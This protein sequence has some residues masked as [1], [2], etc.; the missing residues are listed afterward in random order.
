MSGFDANAF[1]NNE[2]ELSDPR[3]VAAQPSAPQASIKFNANDFLGN[4]EGIGDTSNL[5]QRLADYEKSAP[6][7]TFGQQLGAIAEGAA[8]GL[9]GPVATGVE[10]GLSKYGFP[11]LTPENQET[12][13]KNFPLE[14]YGSEVA[15][16]GL[17]SLYGVGEAG[18]VAK[19]GHAAVEASDLA[20]GAKLTRAAVSGGSELAAIQA[21]NEVSSAI[22]QDP[23][24]TLG[25]AAIHMTL[26]GVL[27]AAGGAALGVPGKMWSSYTGQ[28]AKD[29]GVGTAA[30]SDGED[31][32]SQAIQKPAEKARF[33]DGL[34]KQK[35]NADEI[36]AAGDLI[37]VPV[38]SSQTS[39][40]DFVQSLDSALSQSPT[41]AGVVR[42]QEIDNGFE[43]IGNIV[44]G[45]MGP[46][47]ETSH[48][49]RGQVIKDQIQRKVDELYDPLRAG[50]ASRGETNKAI[51]IPDNARLKFYDK[52]TEISQ[53]TGEVDGPGEKV[54]SD[55]A[56][57]MLKQNT[58]A[59]LDDLISA[60]GNE[61][62]S[63][64]G[65]QQDHVAH[66]IGL[67]Q[68]EIKQF[69]VKQIALA[70]KNLEKLGVTGA[71]NIAS[72]AVEEFK[73]LSKKYADF[74]DTLTELATGSKLG[75]G[76]STYG[77]VEHVL[78]KIP[79]EKLVEK[80]FDPKNSS[81]L[82]TMKEKFPE[83]FESVIKGKRSDMVAAANGNN[84]SLLDSI[85]G[86]NKKGV[87][88]LS[89]EIRAMM[90]TPEEL[91]MMKAS[92]TWIE[93]L[94]KNVGPSGTPKGQA[95][96]SQLNR[97]VDH[98]LETVIGNSKDFAI[99][100]LLK[101]ATPQ[102]LEK[103]KALGEY[104]NSSISGEKTLDRA[105]KAFLKSGEIIPQHLMPNEKSR[106][107]LKKHLESMNEN[108]SSMINVGGNI[109]HY[110]PNHA[111]AAGTIAAVAQ[112]YFNS[113]KPTQLVRSP[114][115]EKPPVDKMAEYKYNRALDIAQQ[116]LMVLQHAKNGT[117]QA[118]DLQTVGALYPSLRGQIA[119]KL[120][121]E[122]I[123]HVNA[124]KPIPYIERQMLSMLIGSPL[125]STMTQA[126]AQSIMISN[127]PAQQ[128][129]AS[130]HGKPHKASGTTLTQ[131]NK[132]NSMLQTP[133]EQRQMNRKA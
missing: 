55:I 25:T 68:Q 45:I 80:M 133:L 124:K 82:E 35:P 4:E 41:I 61:Q 5:D 121:T 78:E 81:A 108:P 103:N 93:S 114:L 71:E 85:F 19:L 20:K 54:I 106:D 97:L 70:G 122:M 49:V 43:K 109:G 21:G 65:A 62:R 3:P 51:Q 18:L 50:Y 73:T 40:S 1:L 36:K 107:R 33:L 116:P 86:V 53:K 24:Q 11:G 44:D 117:L 125:D 74:K 132:V 46:V 128:Q 31:I 100:T 16:F 13:A 47:D 34:K 104:I 17:S 94:P 63:A 95:Y 91:Q 130:Q 2:P 111:A 15:S 105:A 8:Q 99:K 96:M 79:N 22:N 127:S 29:A 69:Q 10:A 37:G 39:A 23:N 14:R 57:R 30:V 92:R 98:P 87:P 6:D 27:G 28:A 126:A 84:K 102:E 118:Q 58:A 110:L 38:S 64:Y 88:N 59:N 72:Q 56:E 76:F 7:R 66:A 9:L 67:A 83:V 119:S 120:S 89:P 129:A 112:N 32:L 101:F 131:I 60:L 123:D 52:L 77:R 113:L 90:F 26:A 115:D 48:A 42:K 12:R 75:K